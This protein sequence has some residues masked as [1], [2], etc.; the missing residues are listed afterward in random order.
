M[1]KARTPFQALGAFALGLGLCGLV[2]AP[3][4]FPVPVYRAWCALA[5]DG[6]VPSPDGFLLTVRPATAGEAGPGSGPWIVLEAQNLTRNPLNVNTLDVFGDEI[7]FRVTDSHGRALEQA[8][9]TGAAIEASWVHRNEV[10]PGARLGWV[11]DVSRW[12]KIPGPGSYRLEAERIAFALGYS[13]RSVSNPI[14]V[15]VF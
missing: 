12:V 8:R 3:A 13:G 14:E 11:C 9:A 7:T 5:Y 2:L 1:A 6:A 15:K 4:L 10:A